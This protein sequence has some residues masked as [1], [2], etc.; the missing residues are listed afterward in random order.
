MSKC[1]NPCDSHRDSLIFLMFPAWYQL[2]TLKKEINLKIDLLVKGGILWR[3]RK[4]LVDSRKEREEREQRDLN[5]SWRKEIV[6]ASWIMME[7]LNEKAKQ[8][9]DEEKLVPAID[10]FWSTP[11]ILWSP[12]CSS[13][14]ILMDLRDKRLQRLESHVWLIISRVNFLSKLMK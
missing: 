5:G 11:Y 9:L 14:R 8:S 10:P 12:H 3:N 13:T 4:S 7:G 2:L 6:I 1:H